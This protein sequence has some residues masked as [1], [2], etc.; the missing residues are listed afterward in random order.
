MNADEYSEWAL[1]QGLQKRPLP[2]RRCK[3]VIWHGPGHQ[4]KTHC[5]E[6]EGHEGH[7]SCVYGSSLRFAEW[8]GDEGMTGPFDEPPRD[9]EDE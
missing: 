7:H 9:L 3:A 6:D 5:S 2:P 8:Y 4:S 1:A